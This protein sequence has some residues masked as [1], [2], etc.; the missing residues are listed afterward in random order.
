[1]LS[2]RFIALV[3]ASIAASAS[4]AVLEA[5]ATIVPSPD[6]EA[7]TLTGCQ[8]HDVCDDIPFTENDCTNLPTRQ[9]NK[10]KSVV[11]PLGW[12]CT[13]FDG[14][15]GCDEAGS[16]ATTTLV[17]PGSANLVKQNFGDRADAFKCFLR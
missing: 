8:T 11:V 15:A 17:A 3:L 12:I 13:L 9:V 16:V 5:S 7:G 4:A 14:S 6:L 1:M 2:T 10:L